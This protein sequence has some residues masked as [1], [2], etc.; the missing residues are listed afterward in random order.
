[1][2][3]N[4]K[5]LRREKRYQRSDSAFRVDAPLDLLSNGPIRKLR[6]C[7]AGVATLVP[8]CLSKPVC[9]LGRCN[10]ASPSSTHRR[11]CAREP[12]HARRRCDSGFLCDVIH[13]MGGDRACDDLS[14]DSANLGQGGRLLRSELG[15]LHDLRDT[16]RAPRAED[17]THL[18]G[19]RAMIP[20]WRPLQKRPN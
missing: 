1:M 18:R 9:A 5:F 7:Q 3:R 12:F 13:R 20:P 15:G 10:T 16:S 2:R 6:L 14:D 17:P 4:E 8:C 11:R 19:L